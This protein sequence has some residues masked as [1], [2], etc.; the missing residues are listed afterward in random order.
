MSPRRA[1]KSGLFS[2]FQVVVNEPSVHTASADASNA[3]PIRSLNFGASSA[4]SAVVAA[5]RLKRKRSGRI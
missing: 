2:E 4:V 5:T 3:R 1:G